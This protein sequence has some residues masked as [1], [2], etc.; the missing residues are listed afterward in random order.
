MNRFLLSGIL[1]LFTAV[2]SASS[3]TLA[4][5]PPSLDIQLHAGLRITG[6]IGTVD[7]ID[8]VTDHALR[9]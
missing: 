9:L 5:T 4:Q 2:N 6:G 7:S 8:Y 1:S 3:Q